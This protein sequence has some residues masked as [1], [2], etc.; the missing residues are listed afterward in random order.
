MA[1]PAASTAAAAASAALATTGAVAL[2]VRYLGPEAGPYLLILAC[3]VSGSLWPLSSEGSMT[4]GEAAGLVVRCS[5]F[6]LLATH[7]LAQV[8]HAKLNVHPDDVLPFL[9]LTIGAMGNTWRSLFAGLSGALARV[10]DRGG[11]QQKDGGK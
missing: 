3:A 10:L 1:E 8:V 2:S 9:A 4:V 5:L 7:G 11:A 6:A